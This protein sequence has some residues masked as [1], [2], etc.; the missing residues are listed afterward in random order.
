MGEH[1]GS[2]ARLLLRPLLRDA[3]P[4]VQEAAAAAL[5]EADFDL[6]PLSIE[7]EL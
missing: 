5:A 3:S 6:D 4:S 1:G 7:Y 2:E